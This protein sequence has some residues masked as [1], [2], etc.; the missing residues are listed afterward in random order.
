M[1]QDIREDILSPGLEYVNIALLS[2]KL[3]VVVI[4]GG[5]AGY[6]KAKSFSEKGCSVTV[7]SKSI[8]TQFK[9][10]KQLPGL[11]LQEDTYE[12]NHIVNAH[13]V[14]IAVDDRV[15]CDKIAAHCEELNKLYLNCSDF[16]KGLYTLPMQRSTKNI[17]FS[18]NTRSGSP[19]TSRHL[20]SV[21]ENTLKEYDPWVEY[22]CSIRERIKNTPLKDEIMEFVSSEDFK[23][24]LQKGM[25]Q[26]VLRM[27]YRGEKYEFKNSDQKE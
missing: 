13:L 19:K 20:C 3:R 24:F 9:C 10:L 1:S 18:I 14:V 22:C 23:F 17:C 26:R 6:I 25:E 7:V 4:G 11:I 5:R 27:F 12:K 16:T 8:S 2:K 21:M 15:L